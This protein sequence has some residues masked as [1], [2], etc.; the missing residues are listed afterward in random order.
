MALVVYVGLR[1]AILHTNFDAVA[2]P[3]YELSTIGNLATVAVEDHGGAP[4]S[5]YFDNVGGHLVV[6]WLAIPLYALFG[7]SYF[8]L[9]LV[10]L[11][12]GL[13]GLW[14]FAAAQFCGSSAAAD[15]GGHG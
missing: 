15:D 10:P 3:N 2:M 5:K 11:L 1:L 14:S 7:S 13:A 9:K 8:V 6:G 12:L 4:L